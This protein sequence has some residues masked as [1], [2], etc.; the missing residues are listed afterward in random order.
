LA[1]AAEDVDASECFG[2][3]REVW[4]FQFLFFALQQLGMHRIDRVGRLCQLPRGFLEGTD[5]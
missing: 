4:N 5:F 1:P 3:I 2:E